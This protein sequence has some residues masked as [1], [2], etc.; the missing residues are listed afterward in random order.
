MNASH[1]TK[2]FLVLASGAGFRRASSSEPTLYH[3]GFYRHVHAGVCT[4]GEEQQ[5]GH[6]SVV[7]RRTRNAELEEQ[8]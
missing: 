8:K 7:T 4:R 2:M 1:A 5:R 6:N 3:R